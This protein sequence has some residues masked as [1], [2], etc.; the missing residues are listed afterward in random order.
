MNIVPTF[1]NETEKCIVC[2]IELPAG[3]G[4][5]HYPDGDYCNTCG[6]KSKWHE[7]FSKMRASEI[8]AYCG[9]EHDPLKGL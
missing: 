2:E 6:E 7:K 3:V 9:I 5:F 4:R 8:L 1:D